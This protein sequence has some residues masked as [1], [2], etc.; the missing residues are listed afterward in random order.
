MINTVRPGVYTSYELSGVLSSGL[1]VG[2]VAVAAVALSG[3]AGTVYDITSY[4]AAIEQFGKGSAM[5]A[6]IKI[7][8]LNGVSHVKAV[9]VATGSGQTADISDYM[10]AFAALSDIDDVKI[11][12]CDS[13]QVSVHEKLKDSILSADE[14]CAYR[15]GIV[16]GS[17]SVSEI[18]QAAENLNCE[19]IV[20]TAPPAMSSENQAVQ[21]GSVA[22]AVAG[23]I[24]SERDPAI[25]LNGA[26]LKGLAGLA[27]K[28]GD[29]D[30]ELLIKGGVTPVESLGGAVSVV[31]GV[32]TK[33]MTA[34]ASDY[35]WRELSTVLITDDVIPTIRESLRGMFS[36]AKNTAQTRG[37]I[38]TQVVIELE[39][40]VAAEIISGYSNVKVAQN[41]SDSTVC[42]VSFE[43]TVAHGINQ[44]QLVAYITV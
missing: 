19:R 21:A 2:T 10:A 6:L 11:V 14:R 44:I 13:T 42:D 22:A 38:R 37:A 24:I 31:R 26:V 7:L 29:G 41:A 3:T 39:K 23:A 20:M 12:I 34:G 18:V 8:I 35:T 28:Y 25:P 43:F 36:C 16:E 40:K 30:A 4:A 15:I 17:G 32:T 1:A 5:A 27:A 9:P 33:T